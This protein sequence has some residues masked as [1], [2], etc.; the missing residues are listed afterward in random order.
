MVIAIGRLTLLLQ[1]WRQRD[2]LDPN[3]RAE[4]RGLVGINEARESVLSRPPV[5]DMW[6]VAGRRLL[7]GERMSVQRTWLWGTATQRW[8]L[9]LEFSAGGQP[10]DRTLLPGMRIEADLCFYPGVVEMRALVANAA[11]RSMTREPALPRESFEQLSTRFAALLGR[12]PWLERTPVVLADVVPLRTKDGAWSLLDA[13]RRCIDLSGGDGWQLLAASGGEAIDVIGE[14]DGFRL[15]PLGVQVAGA[16]S[17][18]RER[19]A[20]A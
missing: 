19:E 7:E 16:V 4:V 8:A 2:A 20:V 15:W 13:E 10:L 14:W 12:N 1:A 18:L 11:P 17:A 6:Q 5:R 9:I 3:L